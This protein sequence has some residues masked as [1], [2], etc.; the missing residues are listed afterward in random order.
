MALVVG[1][2]TRHRPVAGGASDREACSPCTSQAYY[3]LQLDKEP[4]VEGP[5][6]G[7]PERQLE[8]RALTAL[9][10]NAFGV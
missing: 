10:E 1:P 9:L 5:D 3:R 6:C 4:A 2:T 7:F 8:F